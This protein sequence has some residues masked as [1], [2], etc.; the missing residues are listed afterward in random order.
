MRVEELSSTLIHYRQALYADVNSFK[1]SSNFVR[2]NQL[3][4]SSSTIVRSHQFF[5][6]F[7]LL[8]YA[9]INNFYHLPGYPPL[10]PHT[11]SSTILCSHQA[12]ALANSRPLTLTLTLLSTLACSRQLLS[13]LVRIYRYFAVLATLVKNHQQ[14]CSVI[15]VVNFGKLSQ[16]ILRLLTLSYALSPT[17]ARFL[18]LTLIRYYQQS[19]VLISNITKVKGAL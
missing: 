17:L 2:S 15:I 1:Q 11:P 6:T 4:S 19:Y 18:T 14:Y 7:Y 9:P 3:S 5:V 12:C 10:N 8:T 16:T 13:I